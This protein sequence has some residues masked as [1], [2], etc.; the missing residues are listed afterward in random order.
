M[1]KI[2]PTLLILVLLL[3][4]C[5]NPTPTNP[6]DP[7]PTPTNPTP[8]PKPKPVF[9]D[10]LQKIE[11][12]DG[13]DIE[14]GDFDGDGDLDAF[15]VNLNEPDKIYINN[16]NGTFSDSGQSIGGLLSGR[17][18]CSTE[19]V[20]LGDLDGDGDLDAF[21]IAQ[22]SVNDDKVFLNNGRGILFDSEQRLGDGQDVKLGDLDGDGDLDAYL[23][24]SGRSGDSVYLNAG[25][26]T[27]IKS[28]QSLTSS[29][30]VRFDLGDLDGDGDLDV[31]KIGSSQLKLYKNNGDGIFSLF[32]QKNTPII[33]ATQFSTQNF[34]LVPAIDLELGDLDGDGDLDVFALGINKVYFNDGN[35]ILSDSNQSIP[36]SLGLDAELGD[37]DGDG[38]L[39]VFISQSDA[40]NIFYLNSGTGTF[41]YGGKASKNST[42]LNPLVTI[43]NEDKDL[44]TTRSIDLGDLDGDGDLDVFTLNGKNFGKVWFNS[45]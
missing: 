6:T 37:L 36:S 39:D 20:E 16:G 31:L 10:S 4:A 3:V 34:R 44:S 14:L 13:K 45:P 43:I 24:N 38:D 18:C 27:F 15:V 33:N 11:P 22:N 7:N 35:G 23:L 41:V 28:N 40:D 1:K 12:T 25:N 5:S 9:K 29:G 8:T 42:S 2:I 30:Y 26:G 32:L 17:S 19:S 21:V